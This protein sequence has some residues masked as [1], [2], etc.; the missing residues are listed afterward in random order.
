MTDQIHP[1]WGRL[2]DNYDDKYVYD[3][4]AIYQQAMFSPRVIEALHDDG[5][6]AI[7]KLRALGESS[8][9]PDRE[10]PDNQI[11]LLMLHSILQLMPFKCSLTKLGSPLVIRGCI[12]L[13]RSIKRLGR[14]SPF[15]YEYG[16]LCF[17]I[18]NIAFDFCALQLS[19]RYSSW[20]TEM[21]QPQYG[22]LKEGHV[23]MMSQAISEVLSD[24]TREL[25][26]PY[27]P[28]FFASRHWDDSYTGLLITPDDLVLLGK[29]M[30]EDRKHFS[31]FLRSNYELGLSA[32]MYA[33][34]HHIR[35]YVYPSIL[36]NLF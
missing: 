30:D 1:H 3:T 32:L 35:S 17:R 7:G 4:G 10:D 23:P 31:I 25:K 16:Y 29:I 33:M 9:E 27:S 5:T 8:E 14:P 12:K 34:F 13:M 20:A 18:L 6:E 26:D 21:T 11:T 36:P 28:M 15:S 22:F 19:D 2:K 24:C